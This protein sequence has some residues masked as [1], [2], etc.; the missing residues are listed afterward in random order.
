MKK[1]LIYIT[2]LFCL[3]LFAQN[4]PN[5]PEP[6]TGFKRVDLI[7]PKIENQQD[8]KVEIKFSINYNVIECANVSFGFNMKNLKTEY[9][10]ANSRFPYY[11]IE[12]DIIEISEGLSSDC[13]SKTKVD[14]KIFS[15]Q[16]L[17][18]EYQ[19]YYTR[20]FYIPENWTL[21]F[22]IWKADANFNSIN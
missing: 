5:Y 17:F 12:N 21:E 1:L 10:I 11:V 19:S 16:N 3:N 20:P 15:S 6:K 18:L 8:Y 4:K 13:K 2:F 22:R 14:K 7:L 9:G